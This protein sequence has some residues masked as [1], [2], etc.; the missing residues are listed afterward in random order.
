MKKLTI[1]F[2]LFLI[3]AVSPHLRAAD[4]LEIRD[5]V[6]G[7]YAA[8]R[9]YGVNPLLD[10]EHYAQISNDGK[11]IVKYSFKDGKEVG[12]IF[13]VTTARNVKLDRLDG[14]IMSPDES[15]ILIQTKTQKIY[16]RS[17]TAEYYIYSVRNNTLEPLS[18]NGPQQV[19]MFS[20]DGN[21][22]AFVR[23][24]NIFLVKFSINIYFP[25]FDLYRIPRT[26][27][28]PPDIIMGFFI[29]IRQKNDDIALLWRAYHIDKAID[30][31]LF[32]A[33]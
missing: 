2:A 18:E 4:K 24:N 28:Y 23:D 30:K 10:G 20:P 13:D 22:I 8:Q 9:V 1:F 21:N 31:N 15:R 27:N 29:S 26:G 6:S 32:L 7:K 33:L 11:R 3:C 25:I 17:F 5:V 16:R 19:P 12:T 14:Y